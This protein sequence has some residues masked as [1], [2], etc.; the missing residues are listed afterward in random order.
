MTHILCS[1]QP[2]VCLPTGVGVRVA[3]DKQFC[4]PFVSLKDVT[5]GMGVVGPRGDI[6]GAC[7]AR[8]Q[9]TNHHLATS[10][11]L[12]T[13]GTPDPSIIDKSKGNVRSRM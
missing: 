3:R 7:T 1:Q 9:Q 11:V 6:L 5:R 8:T 2:P 10:L 12:F 13:F 4:T